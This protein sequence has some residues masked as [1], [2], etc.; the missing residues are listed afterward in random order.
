MI[1]NAK[2]LKI[3]KQSTATAINRQLRHS[4]GEN[5]INGNITSGKNCIVF[6]K[7]AE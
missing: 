1:I 3:W 2:Q 5:K 6:L 7:P 4:P